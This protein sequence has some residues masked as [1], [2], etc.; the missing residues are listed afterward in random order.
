MGAAPRPP[1]VRSRTEDAVLEIVE[2]YYEI[3]Y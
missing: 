1:Y 3:K 2:K